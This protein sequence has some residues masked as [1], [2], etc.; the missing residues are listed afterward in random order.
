[1]CLRK[2]SIKLICF[3]CLLSLIGCKQKIADTDFGK[4]QTTNHQTTCTS[5]VDQQTTNKK[6]GTQLMIINETQD[7]IFVDDLLDSIEM[8]GK[9][10]SEI[11]IPREVIDTES[12][13]YI[14]TYLDGNIFGTKDYG[15]LHFDE[16]ADDY[17][18]KSI[19]IHVGNLG[20]DECKTR[21]SKKYGNPTEEGEEPFVE[22]DG[23]AVTWATYRFQ[24]IELRLSAAS[25][26]DFTELNI[27]KLTD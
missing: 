3:L 18:A 7:G 9:I 22:I 4:K 6:S 13:F 19:W 15:I 27:E 1:M 10:A 23:G 24:N 2:I 14:H 8:L 16:T 26:R 25:E 17:L 20:Y 12:K 21:L 5:L 11:G